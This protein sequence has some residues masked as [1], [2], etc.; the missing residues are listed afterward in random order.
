MK[1][2]TGSWRLR[3]WGGRGEGGISGGWDREF[4]IRRH[5]VEIFRTLEVGSGRRALL[6]A[7]KPHKQCLFGPVFEE[8]SWNRLQDKYYSKTIQTQNFSKHKKLS[9][10][11]Q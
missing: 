6:G 3:I 4:E 5:P 1:G 7:S 9:E 11:V 2:G 8:L 10:S